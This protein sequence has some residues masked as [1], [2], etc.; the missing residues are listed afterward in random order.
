MPKAKISRDMIIDAALETVRDGGEESLNARSVAQRLDCSTQPVMYH[1]GTIEELKRVIYERAEDLHTEYLLKP[2]GGDAMLNVGLNYIRFAKEEPNLFRFLFQS[3]YAR[4]K[5]IEE[6]TKSDKLEPV[7]AAMFAGDDEKSLSAGRVG[8][9]FFHLAMFI[10][11][12]ASLLAN[13]SL[14]YDENVV[15]DHLVRAYMGAVRASEA[16]GEADL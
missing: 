1:F 9:I 5:S 16:G 7:I 2:G 12:Y 15:R 13:N 3:G 8:E 14:E 10:H 11:G 4:E 6:M